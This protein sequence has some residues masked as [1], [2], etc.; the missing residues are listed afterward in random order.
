MARVEGRL[1]ERIQELAAIDEA[2]RTARAGQGALMLVDGP[3][4]IGKTE[5]LT[6]A[7]TRARGRRMR[8]LVARGGELE[9]S[10]PFAV[11]R[12]LFEPA[13]TRA[14]DAVRDRLLEGAAVHAATV[15]DP[16]AASGP[17]VV[18]ASAVLHGLYWLTANLAADR[19]LLLVIDDLH[20]SDPASI[21]LVGALLR[22]G[23]SAPVLLVL[24]YRPGQ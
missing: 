12:Q 10:F 21:D 17:A 7:I 6:A 4:G 2:L 5:L 11:V 1:L 9:L 22:R 20:W 13:V 18:E 3:P 19:P 8:V 24:A 15:V 16:R 14:E 23:Q